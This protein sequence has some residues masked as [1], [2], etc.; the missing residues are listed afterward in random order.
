MTTQHTTPSRQEAEAAVVAAMAAV[1]ARKAAQVQENA[2]KEV[3]RAYFKATGAQ[4]H[5]A[6]VVPETRRYLDRSKIP[7]AIL[8]AAYKP[9]QQTLKVHLDG[10]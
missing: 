7:P 1:K 10:C 5:G 4:L 3:I 2:A 8:E 9:P 6:S